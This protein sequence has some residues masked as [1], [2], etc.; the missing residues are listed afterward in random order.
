MALEGKRL[1]WYFNV[2]GDTAEVQMPEDVKADGKF[3]NVVMER[4]GSGKHSMTEFSVIFISFF[5]PWH[6]FPIC[7]NAGFSSTVKCPC[8]QKPKKET[9]RSPKVLWR[10]EEIRACSTSW[11][12]TLC[13]TLEVTPVLSKWVLKRTLLLC[14]FVFCYVDE[15]NIEIQ[16]V[17]CP[18]Y[19]CEIYIYIFRAV[20]GATQWWLDSGKAAVLKH[21]CPPH[22]YVPTRLMFP[23]FPAPLKK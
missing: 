20:A 1:R 2:G 18:I 3:N 15:A 10:P 4:W 7:L 16:T 13:S 22:S 12:M 23:K 19:S 14:T 6:D 11:L 9:R 17:Y 5:L 8:P 21:F